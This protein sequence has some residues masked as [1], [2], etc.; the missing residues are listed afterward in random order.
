MIPKVGYQVWYDTKLGVAGIRRIMCWQGLIFG[1]KL[2]GK[3]STSTPTEFC[4]L[5]RSGHRVTHTLAMTEGTTFL[6]LIRQNAMCLGET[7][8]MSNISPQTPEFNRHR[9]KKCR[10][11]SSFVGTT[12]WIRSV[13][14][15]PMFVYPD[16]LWLPCH[17]VAVPDGFRKQVFSWPTNNLIL[18]TILWQRRKPQEGS[19]TTTH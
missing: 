17:H 16:T 9:W 2:A 15:I 6:P 7:F 12:L 3:D 18:D 14:T 1:G 5:R 11:F 13:V 10:G 19:A 4:L 8:A